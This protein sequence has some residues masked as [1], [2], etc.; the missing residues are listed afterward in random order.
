M[1]DGRWPLVCVALV[2]NNL[3]RPLAPKPETEGPAIRAAISPRRTCGGRERAAG[4]LEIGTAQDTPPSP[5]FGHSST[6]DCLMG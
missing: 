5:P 3:A 1:A 4:S 6:L 2:H